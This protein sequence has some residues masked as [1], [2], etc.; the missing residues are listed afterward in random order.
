MTKACELERIAHP[1]TRPAGADNHGI[2]V[3]IRARHT[4]YPQEALI[5]LPAVRPAGSVE[6]IPGRQNYRT[7]QVRRK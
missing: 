2:E 4:L 7:G 6:E 3:L 1:K 5:C